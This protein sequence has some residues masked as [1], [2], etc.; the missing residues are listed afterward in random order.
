LEFKWKLG[1]Q[2][3]HL[4]RSIMIDVKWRQLLQQLPKTHHVELGLLRDHVGVETDVGFE[5]RCCWK[6][7]LRA[8]IETNF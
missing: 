8:L 6:A 4:Q 1:E 7:S 2:V 5:G 3:E